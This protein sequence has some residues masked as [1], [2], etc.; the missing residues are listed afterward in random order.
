MSEVIMQYCSLVN[1]LQELKGMP[2]EHWLEPIQEDKWSTGEIIAHIKAWDIFVWDERFS[3]FIKRSNITPKKGDVEEINRNAAQEAKCGIS[4]NALIDEVIECRRILSRKLQELPIAIW[5]E[6]I[7][8]GDSWITLCEY[9]KGMVEHDNHHKLQIE[10][11]L[12]NKGIE[13]FKQEV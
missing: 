2:E 8:I 7:Q 13:L 12:L 6:K 4:K 11:Y 5:E 9:I 3:Y 10:K 1:W